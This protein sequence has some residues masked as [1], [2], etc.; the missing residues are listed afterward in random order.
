[1]IPWTEYEYQ[2]LRDRYPDGGYRAVAEFFPLRTKQAVLRRA[3]DLGLMS[4][5]NRARKDRE[6]LTWMTKEQQQECRLMRSWRGPVNK[7]VL[8]W[9]V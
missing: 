9:A 4:K 1:M 3:C 8:R 5:V 7:G 2:I 6:R